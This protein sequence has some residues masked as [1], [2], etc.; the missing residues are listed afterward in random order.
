MYFE[1]CPPTARIVPLGENAEIEP[2]KVAT[3]FCVSRSHNFVVAY[4]SDA[5]I[6]VPSGDHDTC[7]IGAECRSVAVERHRDTSRISTLRSLTASCR[8]SGEKA[9]LI[10][11]AMA[12]SVCRG[13]PSRT[14]CMSGILQTFSLGQ[15]P[16]NKPA[17]D[18]SRHLA[19][20]EWFATGRN[21][22]S[23]FGQSQTSTRSLSKLQPN[24]RVP[25]FEKQT[26]Q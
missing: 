7:S 4:M 12:E 3:A 8:P 2:R 13:A 6:R 9:K 1:P 16:A 17:A 11:G 15:T 19:E 5:A 14:R 10:K 18:A 25:S 23:L 21:S 26:A 22:L 24:K 20:M